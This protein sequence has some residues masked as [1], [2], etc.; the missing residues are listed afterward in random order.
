M[1]QQIAD[2]ALMMVLPL[3]ITFTAILMSVSAETRTKIMMGVFLS[4]L[5]VA[6]DC[7]F[8]FAKNSFI[9]Y[10]CDGGLLLSF[11]S[12]FF[13]AIIG[14]IRFDDRAAKVGNIFLAFFMLSA[15]MGIAYWDRPTFIPT[16]DYTAE[17]IAAMNMKYQDYIASFQNGEGGQIL[18]GSDHMVRHRIRTGDQAGKAGS[19]DKD[20]SRLDSYLVD[21]ET[22]IKRMQD[23]INSMDAFGTLPSSISESEREM[24][25]SQALAINNNAIALNKKVLGL[26]HPHKSSDAHKELIQASECVRLAAYALYSY[27]LQENPEQQLIQYRQSRDQIGQMKIY[28]K[29][30]WNATEA[31]QSNNQQQTEQ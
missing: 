7:I 21:A 13:F 20:L 31:L 1:N 3:G 23:I 10:N 28:L 30:F 6:M 25:S 22:V 17:E 9:A 18:P 11:A 12:L 4:F 26:F 15:F 24:R 29:R 2:I 27:T 5:I 16:S 14:F 19:D 8:F